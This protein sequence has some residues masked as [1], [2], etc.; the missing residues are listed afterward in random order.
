MFKNT[1]TYLVS[2]KNVMFKIIILVQ[3]FIQNIIVQFNKNI[4]NYCIFTITAVI[5]FSNDWVEIK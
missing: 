5:K 3:L 1:L 2:L 4:N